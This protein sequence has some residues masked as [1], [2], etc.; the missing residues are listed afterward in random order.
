MGF[1]ALDFDKIYEYAGKEFLELVKTE[2]NIVKLFTILIGILP[3]K[4]SIKQD[5]SKKK[6]SSIRIEATGNRSLNKSLLFRIPLNTV[7]ISGM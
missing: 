6:A 5:G 2:Q 4:F 3:L 1:S 7:N